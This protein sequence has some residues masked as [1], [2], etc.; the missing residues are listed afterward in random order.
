LIKRLRVFAGPNGSGKSTIQ[1]WVSS[2][3]N[4]GY[5]INADNIEK[6]LRQNKSIPFGDFHVSISSWEF[7]QALSESGFKKKQDLSA[8]VRKMMVSNNVLKLKEEIQDY[9]YLGAIISEL[10]RNKL[11]LGNEDFSFETV[12][13][14]PGK[15]DF[16]KNAKSRGFKTYLYFVSM[17]SP[18][19]NKLRVQ[20]R[21]QSGGHDVPGDKIVSRYYRSMDLLAEAVDCVDRAFLFDNS[22]YG[23][24]TLLAEKDEDEMQI[25]TDKVPKWF[26]DYLINKLF[27]K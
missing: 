24:T 3:Y 4:I 1:A 19:L 25:L 15:L 21:V 18:N 20:T 12:M 9:A 14:H 17:E 26:S 11:V 27:G 22:N 6:I 23:Y 8:L 16:L 13:S 2:R 10:I 5:F 7:K